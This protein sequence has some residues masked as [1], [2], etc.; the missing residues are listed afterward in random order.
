ML[1]EPTTGLDSWHALD[2]MTAVHNLSHEML[3][4]MCTIH[5]PSAAVF[6]LFHS[7]L[8]LSAGNV[9]YFGPAKDA[10]AFFAEE[11]GVALVNLATNPADFVLDVAAGR[12]CLKTGAT[13]G[14]EG[15][16]R[17]YVRSKQYSALQSDLETRVK[18]WVDREGGANA[19]AGT[20]TMLSERPYHTST[21]VQTTTLCRRAWLRTI[22]DPAAVIS[23]FVRHLII[24]IFYG[25]LY[26]GLASGTEVAVYTNRLA[27]LFYALMFVMFSNIQHTTVVFE[28]RLCFY[29]ERAANA[30]GALPYFISTFVVSIPASFVN[31]LVFS[32]VLYNMAGLYPSAGRFW[33]FFAV[34]FACSL[35]GL[36]LCHLVANNSS[37]ISSTLAVLPIFIFLNVMLSGY[38]VLLP[39]LPLWISTWAPLLSFMRWSFQALVLNEFVGN[40]SLPYGEFYLTDL[41]FLSPDKDTCL[42]ILCFFTVTFMVTTIL[43]L[44]YINYDKR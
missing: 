15:L 39:D 25:S 7:L 29:R 13:V 1:V 5:Q 41:D 33:F 36:F 35:T 27:L 30:Y 21:W 32:A 40:P 18:S 2:T 28:N 4:V 14:V 19:D 42:G 38:I 3:T 44:K 9:V 31:V 10:S 20:I 16:A 12:L 37:S 17:H 43:T 8:L 24:A 6:A 34:L 23:Y 22:R 26:F 11:V